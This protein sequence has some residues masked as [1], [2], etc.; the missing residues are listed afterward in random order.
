MWVACSCYRV[1]CS[2]RRQTRAADGMTGRLRN[3]VMLHLPSRSAAW[4]R[5]KRTQRGSLLAGASAI[6]GQL[7]RPIRA[8]QVG[9]DRA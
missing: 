6:E 9:A 1:R 5:A 4:R 7:C 8:Q 2:V 3:P